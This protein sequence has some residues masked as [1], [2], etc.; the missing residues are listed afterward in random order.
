MKR[1]FSGKAWACSLTLSLCLLPVSP[2]IAATESPK[3]ANSKTEDAQKKDEKGEKSA[4]SAEKIKK[5]LESEDIFGEQF[6]VS[7]F[8]QGD[9]IVVQTWQDPRSKDPDHDYRIHS[10]LIAKKLL[11]AFPD[12]PK[13]CRVRYFDR[14][15]FKKYLEFTVVPGVV[16]GFVSGIIPENELLTTLPMKTVEPDKSNTETEV[17]AADKTIAASS[18]HANTSEQSNA[19]KGVTEIAAASTSNPAASKLTVSAS[20]PPVSKPAPIDPSTLN[21][22]LPGIE[23]AA[24][25]DLLSRIQDLEKKGVK[26]P[27]VRQMMAGIE[28]AARD[29]RESDAKTNIERL[30]S[31]IDGMERNYQKAKATKAS[32]ATVSS[33]QS[34]GSSSGGSSSSIT[35]SDDQFKQ[36]IAIYKK[37]MG[38]FYPH[39]GPFYVDRYN[40]GEAILKMQAMKANVDM[41]RA[42]FLQMES[43]VINGRYG[44]ET[45]IK[46]L[47]ELLNLKEA[48]R[49]DEYM[50]QQKLAD[51]R[52]GLDKD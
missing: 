13:T 44:V 45:Q 18:T 25:A 24:R 15:D 52:K 32:P 9:E 26:S 28:E 17:K 11:D 47:N 48:V 21:S 34:G 27:L 43:T 6:K 38:D 23:Q 35:S 37:K 30:K 42:P 41:Y 7:S 4:V 40:I 2:S 16:K 19:S 12:S 3:A 10:V 1:A 39:Y 8:L 51:Q 49:D 20:N 14:M 31:S 29:G 5:V 22:V 36:G 33:R 46:K 50:L